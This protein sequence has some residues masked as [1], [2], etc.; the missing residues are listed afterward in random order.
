MSGHRPQAK[1]IPDVQVL[2]ALDDAILTGALRETRSR[3]VHLSDFYVRLPFPS[4]VV[5]AKLRS[6]VRRGVI[7]AQCVCG[8]GGPYCRNE[9]SPW[10]GALQKGKPVKP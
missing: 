4:K 7:D 2:A 1:D 3:Q 5:L 6:M 8:C 9:D 10:G